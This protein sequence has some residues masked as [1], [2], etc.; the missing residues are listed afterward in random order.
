M[1][2]REFNLI[3][4]NFEINQCLN[5]FEFQSAEACPKLNFYVIWQFISKFSV[6][7]GAVLILVGL[8]ETFYGAKIMIVTIFLATCMA[9][10]TVVFI[11][12]FQ[13]II[14]SGGSPAIVWVVLGISILIGIV[15]GYIVS[16]YN[17]AV[18]GMILGGYMGYILGLILY[19]SVF[20]KIESNPTVNLIIIIIYRL[21]T[22]LPC[23]FLLVLVSSL[24]IS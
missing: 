6:I 7:F 12:L 1:K 15:L 11:F 14:P 17:K 5:T 21:C 18:I 3:S 13:F 9:T 2:S 10:V 24:H 19:N 23:C 22:G 8:F 16:R 20:V 4:A